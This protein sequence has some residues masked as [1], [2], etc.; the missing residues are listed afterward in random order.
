VRRD[1]GTSVPLPFFNTAPPSAA[2][3]LSE[4]PDFSV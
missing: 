2:A 4:F 3:A 1:T